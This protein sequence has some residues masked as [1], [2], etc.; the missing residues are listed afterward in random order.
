MG[1]Q[2]RERALLEP[3]QGRLP[4]GGGAW[5]GRERRSDGLSREEGTAQAEGNVLP[6][7]NCWTPGAKRQ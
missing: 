1:L 5:P 2:G 3:N 4:G 6:P 7:Q